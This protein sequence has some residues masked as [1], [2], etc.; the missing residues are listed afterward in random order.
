M[1]DYCAFRELLRFLAQLYA[2]E[3]RPGG[4]EAAAALQSAVAH[5][6]RRLPEPYN[7]MPGMAET[8]L[9]LGPHPKAGVV[10]AALPLVR[11][12]H[13]TDA[14]QSIGAEMGGKMLVSELLGPDGM[15]RHAKVRVGL[16]VQ[17]P[18][19]DYATRTHSAEETY[20]ILG[21]EGYWSTG[22]N[23]PEVKRAGDVVFHPS[24]VPH[25]SRTGEKPTIASWRWS[26]DISYEAYDCA[27]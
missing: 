24:N 21:G 1:Q 23:D 8:A 14:M 11:W 18:G 15:I 26:G 16:F 7:Y 2:A 27:G 6:P 20:M 10:A 9:S 25:R 19:L 3:G 12:F 4:D 17:C 22:S 13:V 5:F